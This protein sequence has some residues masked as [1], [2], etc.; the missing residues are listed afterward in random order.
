MKKTCTLLS[1]LLITKLSLAQSSFYGEL[2]L[3]MADNAKDIQQSSL[4]TIT[5]NYSQDHGTTTTFGGRLGYY[6]ND[7]VAF[8]LGLHSFGET[9]TNLQSKD[10]ERVT[11]KI[12]TAS[13]SA[14]IKLQF[15]IFDNVSLFGRT[16]YARWNY[17]AKSTQVENPETLSKTFDDND[18]YF[19]L[20]AQYK[21]TK[22]ISIGLEYF[23]QKMDFSYSDDTNSQFSDLNNNAPAPTTTYVDYNIENIALS[24]TMRF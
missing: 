19:A 2:S 4:N 7:F 5:E 13:G 16:G 12:S 11:E 3:G 22:T 1:L 23:V 21:V 6:F 15:P 9:D 14:G 8:E 10:G 18:V 17:K 20:G 24:A